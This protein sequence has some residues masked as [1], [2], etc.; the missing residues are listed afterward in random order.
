MLSH[1]RDER[2]RG[3]MPE[4]LPQQPVVI[5]DD[6]GE[7]IRDLRRRLGLT[8]MLLAERLGVSFATVNR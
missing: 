3:P 8:Q 7:R 4:S 1:A 2:N 5:P 6:C